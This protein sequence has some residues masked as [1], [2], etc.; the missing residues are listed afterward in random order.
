MLQIL[1]LINFYCGINLHPWQK[2]NNESESSLRR[3]LLMQEEQSK[4][5]VSEKV[6]RMKMTKEWIRRIRDTH[7]HTKTNHMKK[8]KKKMRSWRNENDWDE[9]I[10]SQDNVKDGT[11]LPNTNYIYIHTRSCVRMIANKWVLKTDAPNEMRWKKSK[12]AEVEVDGREIEIEKWVKERA[13]RL[14]KARWF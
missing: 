13:R 5:E 4:I 10:F 12:S 14:N 6:S 7:T 8:K 2:G 1:L 11:L 9:K 3:K